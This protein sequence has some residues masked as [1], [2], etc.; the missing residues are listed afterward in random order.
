MQDGAATTVGARLMQVVDETILPRRYLVLAAAA[1]TFAFLW[2][3]LNHAA[4]GDWFLF[5]TK[6]RALGS[7]ND[8]G[9][10]VGPLVLLF[11]WPFSFASVSTGWIAVSMICMLLGLLAIRCVERTA[12]LA[13]MGTRR[14]RE[15]AVLIGG[16]FLMYVWALP[17]ARWGHADDVIVLTCTALAGRAIVSKRWFWASIAIAFAVDTKSWAGLALPLVAA[18]SG[19]RLRGLVVAVVAI[20]V[21]LVPF[22]VI[23]H[24]HLDTSTLDLPV[25]EDSLVR[26]LG[27]A[28]GSHPSWP[29]DLQLLV[30]LPLGAWSVG[31]GRWYL[32]PVIAFGVRLALD[33]ATAP[34]YMAGAV[35]GLFVWDVMRPLRLA[36]VRAAA[37]CVALSLLPTELDGFHVYGSA[38]QL[39]VIGLRVLTVLAPTFVLLRGAGGTTRPEPGSR[40]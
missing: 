4:G 6:A 11:A 21:P 8:I 10:Y 12:E 3:G 22:L 29:R 20:L 15:R 26:Y 31:R 40:R 13:G 37:G 23:H 9:V 24:G 2:L 27:A 14:Q 35:F 17:G 39:V 38:G 18:C 28:A 36:G 5:T 34:Y 16:V 32:V 25:A 19:R 1:A 33:P 30:A 7:V